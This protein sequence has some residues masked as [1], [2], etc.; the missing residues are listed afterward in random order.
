MPYHLDKFYNRILAIVLKVNLSGQQRMTHQI[1]IDGL[2]AL[3]AF[4]NCPDHQ[5]L[6]AAHITG[7]EYIVD[8]SLIIIGIG[9]DVAARVEFDA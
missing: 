3:A 5:R 1:G 6:A 2:R 7:G 9:F 4:A 8:G